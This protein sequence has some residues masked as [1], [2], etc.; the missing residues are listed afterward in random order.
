L[1]KYQSDAVSIINRR[2]LW[3]RLAPKIL[4]KM[5]LW[6]HSTAAVVDKKATLIT[7]VKLNATNTSKKT[8]K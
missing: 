4:T 2:T 3:I 5:I 6:S 7:P 8:A 1:E